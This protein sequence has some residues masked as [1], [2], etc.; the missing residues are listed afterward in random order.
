MRLLIHIYEASQD[1]TLHKSQSA[2]RERE[3]ERERESM[4]LLKT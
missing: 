4:G 1:L 2:P 3:R